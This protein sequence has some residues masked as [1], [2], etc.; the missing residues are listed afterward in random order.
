M[1]AYCGLDCSKCIGYLATKSGSKEAL[2][3][4]AKKWSV[5]FEADITAEHV[6]CDGC[7]GSERKSYHCGNLCKI[8]KCCIGKDLQSCIECKEYPC[9]DLGFVLDNAPDAKNNLEKLRDNR[10][11]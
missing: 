9:S 8:R 7:K 1:I 2:D 10:E 4:V 3:D 6:V 5:Q 11:A